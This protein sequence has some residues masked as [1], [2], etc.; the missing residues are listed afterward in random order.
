LKQVTLVAIYGQKLRAFEKYVGRCVN[1]IVH[2]PLRRFFKPYHINQMHATIVGMEK[3]IGFNEPF[4]ANIWRAEGKQKEM[5]I[6]LLLNI[7]KNHHGFKIKFGGFGLDNLEIDSFGISAYFRSFELQ[8]AS[9]KVMIMGWHHDNDGFS[10]Y[11][12]LWTLRKQLSDECNVM[13][14][15]QNDS[16]FF[17]AI[18]DL[19]NLDTLTDLE[20]KRLKEAG[21]QV[22]RDIRKELAND[23]DLKLDLTIDYNSMYIAQYERETLALESTNVFSIARK[24]VDNNLISSLYEC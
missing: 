4:N 11:T 24:D 22:E 16:D 21:K 10:K 18:G 3:L 8:W 17:V 23:S 7:V 1:H 13:H 19:I 20:L 9:N 15:Y 12:D 14:K 6:D 5:D 2:S